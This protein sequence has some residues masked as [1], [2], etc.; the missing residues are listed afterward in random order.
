MPHIPRKKYQNFGDI[1]DET[2]QHIGLKQIDLTKKYQIDHSTISTDRKEI[3]TRRRMMKYWP[4]M[5]DYK[6][7]EDF[8]LRGLYPIIIDEEAQRREAQ[9]MIDALLKEK[10]SLEEQLREKQ[11]RS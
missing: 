4:F 6:I 10:Y 8:F 1:L 3:L 11:C 5:E 9:H 7:S 2:L